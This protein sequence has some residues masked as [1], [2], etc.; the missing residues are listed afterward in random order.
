VSDPEVCVYCHY[1]WRAGH[2][3]ACP[4]ETNVYPTLDAE[5]D[6]V[7]GACHE[8][9]GEFWTVSDSVIVCLGCAAHAS[10]RTIG[11]LYRSEQ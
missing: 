9:L 6:I 3:L 5:V 8:S 7:C 2:S 11:N 4:Q 10:I 1:L